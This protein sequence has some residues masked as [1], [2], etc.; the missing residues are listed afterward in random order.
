MEKGK[1][2]VTVE[3]IFP[4]IKTFLYSDNEIFIRELVSNA[5]DAILK[6]KTLINLGK[7]NKKIDDLIIEIVIDK[8]NKILKIID[9]G[10]GMTKKEVKKYINQIAFSGAEEFLR[11]YKDKNN[12]YI[13]GNFGLGF[14]SSFMVSDKVEIISKSYKDSEDA[15]HW[16]C[17]GTTNFSIKNIANTITGSGTE[18]ILHIND[19][20]K[21]FLEENKIKELL[22]KYCKFMP[23]PIKLG[24]REVNNPY[25]IWK[26][27]P[28]N[29]KDEEYINFYKELYPLQIADP[30][31]WIHL[32]IDHPFNLT[33]VLFFPKIKNK[34]EIQRDKIQLYKN[35][36]YVTDNLEGIVPDFLNLLKGVIDSPDIPLNVSRSYLQSESSVKQISG[37][38]TRKVAEKLENMCKNNREDFEKNWEDIKI[39]IEYGMISDSNFYSKAKKFALYPD[40]NHQY[41]LLE[42]YIKKANKF[43]NKKIICFYTSNIE[44]QNSYIETIKNKGYIILLLDS[45]IV[46]H[47]LQKIE[48]DY[49]N[50]NFFRVDSDQIDKILKNNKNIY[51]LSKEEIK[52]LENILKQNI[53]NH[54]FIIKIEDLSDFSLPFIIT[55]PEFIRRMKEISM[56][57]NNMF[58]CNS[59]YNLIVNKNHKLIKKIINEK[60]LKTKKN[61]IKNSL[62]LIMLSQNLLTGKELTDFI[63]NSFEMLSK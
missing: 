3:D 4:V 27:N 47:L 36:V 6:L 59:K 35:Q 22:I 38:I 43:K 13:I 50:I 37:Y 45:P 30:L 9:N 51:N 28:I 5:T 31:F 57:G 25:P 14:Y 62:H 53:D 8:E 12:E 16:I 34:I 40:I 39:I 60:D 11:K 1:I 23:I 52:I 2:Q 61:L 46:G 55:V 56:T 42:E 19:S 58:N 18:I 20:S 44:N 24:E 10:I 17:D 49:K 26:K 7:I 41:F 33:G 15:I 48:M 21:E 29:V 63:Y 32:N 54:K